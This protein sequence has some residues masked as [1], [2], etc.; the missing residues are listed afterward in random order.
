M[1]LIFDRT[2]FTEEVYARLGYKEYEFSDVYQSLVHKLEDL[3]Y[4]IYLVILYLEDT[5]IFK[6]RLA[7][8]SHH[9]YQAFSIE[10]SINQQN[11]YLK[12]GEELKETKIKVIPLS[13]DDFE[14]VYLKLDKIFNI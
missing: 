8:E 1:D 11:M 7:R 13:M 10:N 9:N 2:F 6:E 12:M 4:D 5:S 3:N 14:K